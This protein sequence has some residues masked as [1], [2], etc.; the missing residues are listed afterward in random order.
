MMLLYLVPDQSVV[1]TTGS[2]PGGF[3]LADF[4]RCCA[5][6]AG[7]MFPLPPN[8]GMPEQKKWLVLSFTSFSAT[9]SVA[10]PP[11]LERRRSRFFGRL[12]SPFYSLNFFSLHF[13]PSNFPLSIFPLSI[14]PLSNF[15][16]SIFPVSILHSLHSSLSPFFTISIL[17][18]LHSS[19]S[20]LFTLSI[21]HSLHSSLSPFF[22]LHSPLSHS[23]LSLLLSPFTSLLSSCSLPIVLSFY[24]TILFTMTI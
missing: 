24:F 12:I 19:L 13:S 9:P 11:F 8:L 1:A 15:P 2:G 4:N 3:R 20:P 17:H 16:L 21:L 6:Q 22:T 18:F 7:T 23:P 5:A 14:F 10:E